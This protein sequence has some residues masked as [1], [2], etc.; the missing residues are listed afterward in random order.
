MPSPFDHA[1][2]R[3]GCTLCDTEY[4]QAA[5]CPRAVRNLL[6]LAAGLMAIDMEDLDGHIPKNAAVLD[7]PDVRRRGRSAS[8]AGHDLLAT[9]SRTSFP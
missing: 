3:L 8:G 2:F 4:G 5:V 6:K 1:P 7:G 9:R